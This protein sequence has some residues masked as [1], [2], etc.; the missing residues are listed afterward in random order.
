[1]IRARIQ[2]R[3]GPREVAKEFTAIRKRELA[4]VAQRWHREILPHHFTT[5]AMA[6]YGYQPRDK[7]YSILKAK[8]KGHTRPLEWSGALKGMVTRMAR[9]S[10]TGKSARASLTG[11]RYLY[12]YRKAEGQPDKAAEL[13]ATTLQEAQS[14]GRQFR[15]RVARQLNAVQTTSKHGS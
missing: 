11:P 2:Y 12:A 8:K 13:T 15:H 3:G 1:M 4:L 9:I 6:R 10:G 5:T 14:L 7:W